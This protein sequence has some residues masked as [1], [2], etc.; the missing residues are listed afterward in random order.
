MKIAYVITRSDVIGGASVHLLDLALGAQQAGHDVVILVGGA[1]VFLK[2]AQQLGL[3]CVA[4]KYMVREINVI[5]DYQAYLELRKIFQA[6]EPQLVH[7]HSSKAGVLG[8]LAGRRLAIPTIFTAHG[9]AFTEGVSPAKRRA[10]ILI[11]R[12]LARFA[13]RIIAVS[14]Y[15]RNLAIRAGVGNRDLIA[16]I[17]NG[18]PNLQPAINVDKRTGPVRLIMVARFDAPK[19]QSDLLSALRGLRKYDWV[20]EFVGDGPTLMDVQQQART[21]GLSDHVVFSG[22]CDD[23][24]DRLQNSD[25]FILVSD[26]E[27][28]PLSILEAMRAGLPVIASNVGGI[29]EAVSDGVNGLLANRQDMSALRSAI[30]RLIAHPEV[31]IEMGE[32]GRRRFENEFTFEKMLART[33]DVY[34]ST[35]KA[36]H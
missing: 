7:V 32:A 15:D 33:L 12:L 2:K 31:R 3:R 6:L 24:P 1:G 8:R 29:P 17:H 4:L 19:K 34:D 13:S 28:L 5:K 9:W 11:E 22:A 16:T 23:V 18:M 21:M 25:I 26:W 20:V 27:G 30:E 35:L 10:Y 36:A 14:D